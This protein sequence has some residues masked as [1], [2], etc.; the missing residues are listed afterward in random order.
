MIPSPPGSSIKT[1]TTTS[2]CRPGVASTRIDRRDAHTSHRP[3]FTGPQ[4]PLST[5][6][7]E[8]RADDSWVCRSVP[9]GGGSVGWVAPV[10]VPCRVSPAAIDVG[11]NLG[12]MTETKQLLLLRHAKSS[13]DDPSLAD[14]DRP[15]AP[16]GRKAAKRI[17]A[18]V[19]RERIA[20]G[21]VLCSSARRAH[22]TLEL[23]APPGEI[24]IEPELYRATAA[25]L[26]ALAS[27]ARR[28]RRGD[29]DRARAGDP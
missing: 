2:L 1:L 28:G 9:Q 22:E 4:Q 8:P 6:H 15:L 10:G 7:R 16:R 5:S 29:A 19:R 13:W 24:V 23:V 20:V 26:L 12:A 18:Y 11:E 25:E 14:A 3:P 17:R 21:L 27:R